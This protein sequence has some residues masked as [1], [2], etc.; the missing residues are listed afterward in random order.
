M[1]SILIFLVSLRHDTMPGYLAVEITFAGKEIQLLG[2]SETR[3]TSK[4]LAGKESREENQGKTGGD[5]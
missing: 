4:Y 2:S 3:K 5:P 1:V